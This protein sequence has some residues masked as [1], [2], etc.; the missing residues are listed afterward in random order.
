MPA[1]WLHALRSRPGG[2][3]RAG[4]PWAM[5]PRGTGPHGEMAQM[6][7]RHGFRPPEIAVETRS[8]VVLKSLVIDAGFLS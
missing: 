7:A 1:T 5:E 3:R 6:F 8:I 2:G 4:Q